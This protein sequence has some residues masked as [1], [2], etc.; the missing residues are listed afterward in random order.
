MD[1]EFSIQWTESR[2]HTFDVNVS[3]A[4]VIA[5]FAEHAPDVLTDAI[6]DAIEAAIYDVDRMGPV[7]EALRVHVGASPDDDTLD[8]LNDTAA[9]LV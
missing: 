1:K 4:D 8:D 7:L 6:T 5:I 9:C 3:V 2:T